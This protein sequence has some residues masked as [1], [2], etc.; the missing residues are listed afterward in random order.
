ML[1]DFFSFNS[2]ES[3][4]SVRQTPPPPPPPLRNDQKYLK[5][6]YTH[7]VLWINIRKKSPC[8]TDPYIVK[9]RFEGVKKKINNACYSKVNNAII[10][11]T[12]IK[13]IFILK[14]LVHL[15]VFSATQHVPVSVAIRCNITRTS[16]FVALDVP[17]RATCYKIIHE[18]A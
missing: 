4:L 9:M 1:N 17:T 3:F 8:E 18:R 11:Q 16:T 12:L 14:Y 6:C 10:F 7:F 5:C 2:T 13:S 15:A